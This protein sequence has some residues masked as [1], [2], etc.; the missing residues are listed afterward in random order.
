MILQVMAQIGCYVPADAAI[1]RPIDVMFA[2][3]YLDDDIEFG[4]STFCLEVLEF[5]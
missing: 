3:V 1:F 2:R 4:G 5:Y